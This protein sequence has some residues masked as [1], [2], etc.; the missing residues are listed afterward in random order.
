MRY[1][2]HIRIA[3]RSNAFELT[4]SPEPLLFAQSHDVL[5]SPT[6]GY[7][8][9]IFDLTS[10]FKIYIHMHERAAEPPQFLFDKMGMVL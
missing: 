9:D 8:F 4:P 5:D 7:S 6:N 2:F 1:H 10:D 3:T